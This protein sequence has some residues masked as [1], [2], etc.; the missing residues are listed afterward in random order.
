MS[1]SRHSIADEASSVAAASSRAVPDAKCLEPISIDDLKKNLIPF[2][3]PQKLISL[4]L[5][6]LAAVCYDYLENI[7]IYDEDLD[8]DDLGQEK[9]SKKFLRAD[10]FLRFLN[11]EAGVRLKVVRD[12]LYMPEDEFL[13]KGGEKKNAEI[14]DNLIKFASSNAAAKQNKKLA[15]L[16]VVRDLLK[17]N[18][19]LNRMTRPG[20]TA[21]YFDGDLEGI[22]FLGERARDLDDTDSDMEDEED[23][24]AAAYLEMEYAP[25]PTLIVKSL[26]ELS[27]GIGWAGKEVIESR[28][29][30]V[31]EHSFEMKDRK[32]LIAC[33]KAIGVLRLE[34]VEMSDDL[35]TK[36]MADFEEKFN[37]YF[38]NFNELF[39]KMDLSLV[40]VVVPEDC[41][42]SHEI[43]KIQVNQLKV[44]VQKATQSKELTLPPRNP[45]P[46]TK[47]IVA[48]DKGAGI[49][50]ESPASVAA[51]GL[52]ATGVIG[53]D[54]VSKFPS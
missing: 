46:T 32:L 37:E 2:N 48:D 53:V 15:L 6:S 49:P 20:Y 14:I 42:E 34:Q 10:K 38:L 54:T 35:M 29:A 18:F 39:Y 13:Q 23:V 25:E 41:A 43:V 36:H 28:I 7:S 17:T 50:S 11:G 16:C 27:S 24:E 47:I 33:L 30:G 44:S 1:L 9:F 19:M 5:Y 26:L 51:K 12:G 45:T 3:R 22:Y 21:P 31:K 4:I 8:S 40:E 52:T